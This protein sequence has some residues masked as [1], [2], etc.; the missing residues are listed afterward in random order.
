MLCPVPAML[1]EAENSEYGIQVSDLQWTWTEETII[2]TIR[3]PKTQ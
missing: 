1:A 3:F 2:E